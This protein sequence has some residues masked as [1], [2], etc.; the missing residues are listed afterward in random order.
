MKKAIR[1][2]FYSGI[3]SALLIGC[4]PQPVAV[5]DKSNPFF[6][7]YNTPFN[8]PPFEKI[9]A[10]HYMPA[11]EQGMA[12]GRE[13]LKKIIENK[14]TPNFENTI[15]AYSRMG[16]LL[17]K[18]NYVF[19]GLTDANTNDSLQKIEVEI[20]PKLSQYSDEISLN[21]ELFNRVKAV[22]DNQA[23][24][25]L[26]DEQKFI[27]EN[28]YKGLVRRGALLSDAQ[29]DTLKSLNQQIS[30]ISVN[31][32]QNVL[33][34]TN[35]FK[36]VIDKEADLKGLP[37][38]VIEGAA[39]IA[40]AM[41]NEGKWVFTTQKPSMLPFLTYAENRDLRKQ[42]YDAYLTRGNHN[43][44]LDNKKNL[45]E[46]VRLR[47]K[48]A[49]LLGYA[50]HA[51]LNLENRMAK[52]PANV[53]ALMD[54]L[55]TPA[56]KVAGEE[57]AQMQKIADREG[58]K[59]KIEP[60]DWWYYAEKLRKEK[61]NL[62][63]NELRPYFKLDNVREGAF[64]VANK[65]YGITF[66]PIENIPL[67][68]KDAKAFEV[69]EA[70][71]KHLAV[72]YMDFYTR[73]S[74]RQGAWCGGYR[75]HKW[76]D[77]K[78]IT[79]IVTLVCNFNNPAGETPS[80][81]S[82]DDVTTL[83]HEFGHAL[84]GIL[85]ANKYGLEYTARDIVELPSQIMEHWAVEPEV[86]K[87][88]AKNYQTG[89]VIPDALVKK[90]QDSKYFNTG[91]DN[92]ELLAATMLDMAYYTQKD[93]VNIDVEKFEKDFLTKIGLIKEIEPR[94]KSTYFLHIIGGY[95]A[96]YYVYTWAAVLDN[97]A[98]E[99]FREKGI[100]DKAT[101]DSFRN[102]ILGP[103]GTLDAKQSYINFRGRDAVIAPLLKNRGLN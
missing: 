52:T 47:A 48:R 85:S 58:A 92:V 17:N 2:L 73:A 98:F 53:T 37:A 36:L 86:L 82:L 44:S 87:M 57:L 77:G 54:Q 4:K 21:Q 74:K 70:N 31:Y 46:L 90:I 94:Y 22:Y 14:E 13:D 16:E 55:W 61:Y 45:A 62:D 29:K 15:E 78:E 64:A 63:D 39:A 56:L 50:T 23:S 91:F 5:A 67:T 8:V 42:L 76:Q 89:E 103:M 66:T 12:E 95:D 83:F 88:Y 72:L 28:F 97:D 49:K 27:L 41:G 84:Q 60:S 9:M 33:T 3:V 65:L 51:D 26:N 43:D 20:S 32:S 10:K 81:L 75:D 11:F 40:K 96:G 25:N 18:V 24:M 59:F 79:P 30:V 99:A 101:A 100:F 38:G 19:G 102:N 93:P 1:A 68:H 34:E 71:G 6:S 69:K 80:L 35:K 7:D